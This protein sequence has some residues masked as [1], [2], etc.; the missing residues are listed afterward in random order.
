M[1]EK[2]RYQS[3]SSH[4]ISLPLLTPPQSPGAH[5]IF[6][7]P[8]HVNSTNNSLFQVVA[9]PFSLFSFPHLYFTG[10][11]HTRRWGTNKSIFGP[12]TGTAREMSLCL[13]V[14]GVIGKRRA[15]SQSSS[16][17]DTTRCRDPC[18]HPF[19]ITAK[20]ESIK[21]YPPINLNSHRFSLYTSI[22]TRHHF[23]Q[24]LFQHTS[25]WVSTFFTCV[26]AWVIV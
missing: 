7:R 12:F 20:Q 25:Q 26:F 9:S 19:H 2:F 8:V 6:L 18:M 1:I 4:S 14:S 13:F 11:R 16:R 24:T 22:S 10:S 21:R 5:P 3:W 17:A 23:R 15:N